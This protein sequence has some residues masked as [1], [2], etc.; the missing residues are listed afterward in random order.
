MEHQIYA[1]LYY[2]F[3]EGSEVS[4]IDIDEKYFTNKDKAINHLLELGYKHICDDEYQLAWY[5]HAEIF[6]LEMEEDKL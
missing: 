1:I 2:G 5:L 3:N 6:L 4:N